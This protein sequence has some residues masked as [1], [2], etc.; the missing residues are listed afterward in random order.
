MDKISEL[1][2]RILH[3]QNTVKDQEKEIDHLTHKVNEADLL[4]K[5]ADRYLKVIEALVR[6]TPGSY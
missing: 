1:E 6:Y 2:G 3:Y 5:Q 4:L